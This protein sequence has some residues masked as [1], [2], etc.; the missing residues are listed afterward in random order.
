MR[1]SIHAGLFA[2][3]DHVE[4]DVRKVGLVDRDHAGTIKAFRMPHL[5]TVPG[6]LTSMPEKRPA[7]ASTA[8]YSGC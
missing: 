7:D 4:L 1:A 2:R 3:A 6:E 8:I 5:T